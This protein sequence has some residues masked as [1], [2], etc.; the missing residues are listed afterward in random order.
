LEAYGN[1]DPRP[2]TVPQPPDSDRDVEGEPDLPFTELFSPGEEDEFV[3]E[4]L[5]RLRDELSPRRPGANGPAEESPTP[6]APRER[7]APDA[8]ASSWAEPSAYLEERL[9]VARST[10]GELVVQ[11]KNVG[12]DLEGL[13]SALSAVDREID[14]ATAEIGFL[15]SAPWDEGDGQAVAW[16]VPDAH[17]PPSE[18]GGPQGS[19]RPAEASPSVEKPEVPPASGSYEDFT[20]ARYNRTV[21]ELHRRRL[22]LG[23][24]TVA[25]AVAISGTLLWLTIQA[26]QPV[27]PIWLAALPLVWMIPVPFFVAAFRGTQRVLRENRLEL[28]EEM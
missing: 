15:Q 5:D 3:L 9:S 18:L 4:E 8:V 26:H 13:R 17:A 10:M 6:P 12:Q 25:L 2:G 28:S 21:S 22:A 16:R 24:G 19:G 11:A 7:S 14:R 27:P 23:W 1:E 20:V